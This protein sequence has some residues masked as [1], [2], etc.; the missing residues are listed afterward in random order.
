MCVWADICFFFNS[1]IVIYWPWLVFESL[2]HTCIRCDWF[3]NKQIT[4]TVFSFS[5][6]TKTRPIHIL[7]QKW[8][9]KK[10][11][12]STNMCLLCE[13]ILKHLFSDVN[14]EMKSKLISALRML[15]TINFCL[16]FW[17]IIIIIHWYIWTN[18]FL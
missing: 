6:V 12:H 17:G 13:R 2:W 4:A 1:I 18:V 3:S 15:I 16:S 14:F 9:L 11:H 5:D 8:Q 7:K 10:Y